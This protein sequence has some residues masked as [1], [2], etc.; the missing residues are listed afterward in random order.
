MPDVA[1]AVQPV[2]VSRRRLPDVRRALLY[3]LLVVGGLAMLFPFVWMVSTSLKPDLAVFQTPPQLIPK[4]FQPSNYSTVVHVFPVWRFLGNSAFVAVISVALQ[5]T[6]SAMAAYAFARLKFR[7]SNT[8]FMLYLT[9]LMVPFQVTIVPLFVEMKYLHFVNSYPGL[10]VP[11]IASAYGT[12]LLRQAF[13]GLPSE[14]EEAAFVDGASHWTVFSRIA[15]PL[16]RPSLATFAVLSFIASWNS[17]LWPLVIISSQNLMTLP[18][19]LSNLQGEHLT[20]W[21]LVM[22]G[23]TISV[24]PIVLVYLLAQKQIVRGFVLSGVKG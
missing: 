13:L 7:G 15:L 9:T 1:V 16:V 6:T 10:I 14:L 11:S 21:N 8:L 20:A 17:F 24:L 4:P 12:F 23:A 3:A 18:V 19:G 5:V 22:A 2:L